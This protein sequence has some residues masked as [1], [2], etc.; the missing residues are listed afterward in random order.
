MYMPASGA[1]SSADTALLSGLKDA[2]ALRYLDLTAVDGDP[3]HLRA[4]IL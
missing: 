1:A 2:G 4:G 3:H